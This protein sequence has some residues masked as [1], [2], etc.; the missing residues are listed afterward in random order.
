ME[1]EKL[2]IRNAVLWKID[3]DELNAKLL[4]PFDF[5]QRRFHV[6]EQPLLR[7]DMKSQADIDL[8]RL[9]TGWSPNEIRGQYDMPAVEGG[10][11]SE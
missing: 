4:T 3:A 11:E 6:C 1:P 5:G 8:K 7:L 9:Q 2:G 10:D